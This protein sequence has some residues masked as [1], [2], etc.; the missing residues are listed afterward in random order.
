LQRIQRLS[1]A[2]VPHYIASLHAAAADAFRRFDIAAWTAFW[3]T[4]KGG[5][6]SKRQQKL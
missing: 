1:N 5:P 3:S 2:A 6:N 4:N